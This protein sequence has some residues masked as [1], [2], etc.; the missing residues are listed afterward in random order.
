MHRTKLVLNI[1][2][3]DVTP[4][5]KFKVKLDKVT[6]IMGRTS[7]DDRMVHSV[8]YYIIYIATSTIIYV[9]PT[10]NL[11]H[12]ITPSK[13]PGR[14]GMPSPMSPS[15]TSPSTSRS[16]ATSGDKGNIDSHQTFD[17]FAIYPSWL[18]LCYNLNN[19]L[20]KFNKFTVF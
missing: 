1:S 6:F 19:F 15:I 14:N 7:P 8:L 11:S 16:R 17:K 4:G 10:R 13:V 3:V 2:L 5:T 12:L 18:L 9:V 20:F